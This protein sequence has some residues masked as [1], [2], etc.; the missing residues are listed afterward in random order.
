[1]KKSLMIQGSGGG[2]DK[3]GGTTPVEAADSLRSKQYGRLIDLLGEG[4]IE[5]LVDGMKS[6]YLDG[7]PLQNA[8]N[9]FNF[10]DVVVVSRTGTQTQGYIPGFSSVERVVDVSAEV[11]QSASVTRSIIN[12]NLDALRVTITIPQMTEQDMKNGNLNGSSA[13]IAIDLQTNGGGFVTVVTDTITGKTTSAYQRSYRITL[14]GVGPWDVR[15]RRTTPDSVSTSVSNKTFWADYTTLIDQKLRYP[16]SALVGISI[17]AAQFRGIPSRAYDVK[18]LKVLVPS[19]YFPL[20]RTY[21]RSVTTGTDTGV[22]QAWDGSFYVAWTDNPA[23]CWYDLVTND[24]YGLGDLIDSALVDKWK[25]YTIG[26]YCD[27]LVPNGFGGM[28]PRFTCNIYLQS[29]EEAY[30]VVNSMAAI[31]R[32]MSFWAGGGMTA[33]QDAPADPIALFTPANIIDGVFSYSGSALKARHTVALVTWNDPANGYQQVVEYVEDQVGITRYGVV[34]TE[35]VAMGCTSRGQ[36][37]RAGKWLLFTER[38]ETEIISFKTGLDRAHLY[39]GAV[40]KTQDPSRAGK[41]LGGRILSATA[42]SVVVDSTIEIEAGKLYTLSIV[43]PDGT[44]QDRTLSNLAGPTATLT[45]STAFTVAPQAFAVW[46]VAVSDLVPELWKV[47]ALKE[48]GITQAEIVAVEHYPGKYDLV[49]FGIAFDSIPTSVI[50]IASIPPTGLVATTYVSGPNALDI[51]V[52]WSAAEGTRAATIMWRKG[53]ENFESAVV[54]GNTYTIRNASIGTYTILVS[55]VNSLGVSSS[56]VSFT[57]NVVSA[58]LLP[59]VTGLALKQPFVDKFASFQWNSL[60]LASGYVVEVVV[61]GLTK[62]T[63]T[64]PTNWFVYDYAD[65]LADGGGIPS[66]TFDLRVKAKYGTQLSGNWATVTAT[67]V[68]PPAPA[69]TVIAITGGLQVSAPLPTGSDYAGMIVWGSTTNGFTPGPGNLLYDGTSN[70][71]NILNLTAGIPYYVWVAF[72]DVFGKTGLNMSGQYMVTPLS[73]VADIPVVSTLPTVG[74]EGKVV[75]LTTDDKLYRSNGTAWVTWVDGSD[76]LASSVTAGKISVTE[77]SAIR[78]NLGTI[79]AGNITL[80][81]A[82]FVQGGASG[83]LTGAGFWL[84]YNSTAPAAYKFHLGNPTGQHIKWDGTNL[85]IVGTVSVDYSNI[86]GVKP[87]ADANNTTTV[88]QTG[89]TITGGGITLNGGGVIKVFDNLGV[90]RVKMGNLI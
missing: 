21:T 73:N 89:T 77:L 19:N 27:E 66:R 10:K 6:V 88:L 8:D 5:G 84:G 63:V 85:S 29:R 82:G 16:N 58:I 59:D 36:A 34:Q 38:L 78:S 52:S 44:V 55:T 17:D 70:S 26:K 76:I 62:R 47:V 24:R 40:I 75:Y 71:A 41:R 20:T 61:A 1:M 57:Y 45:P 31:F 9:T 86:T 28:E 42:S 7:T 14:P 51:I 69:A 49:E 25:M 39:P 67:N 4:E 56:Q 30:K 15:V 35:I 74:A 43:L 87:P 33:T 37:H 60:P 32:G 23:W 50:N 68:A 48:S 90:L 81:Q 64:V 11:K 83:Y 13:S 12:P 54:Y 65:S 18:L 72:Y 79:T 2:G 46:V 80:D 22:P 3:G 53:N